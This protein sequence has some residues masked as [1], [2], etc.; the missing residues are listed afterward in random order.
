MYMFYY[1]KIYWQYMKANFSILLAY[2]WGVVHYL[3]STVG[4]TV[5]SILSVVLIAYKTDQVYGWSPEDMFLLACSYNI[6]N[7]L[8]IAIFNK[9]FRYF[10]LLMNEGG[11]DQ[12]L[13][14]PI[15]AQFLLSFQYINYF[16]MVRFLI[17]LFSTVYLVLFY[18]KIPVGFVD[19]LYFSVLMIFSLVVMYALWYTACTLTVWF[20]RLS[21]IID[22]LHSFSG[23]SRNPPEIFLHSRYKILL[24]V[25]PFAF[26]LAVPAKVLL[27][28]VTLNDVFLLIAL[29]FVF[30]VLTRMF[31][32]F[33]L[34]YYS[35]ASS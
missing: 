6:I 4:W 18:L 26:A 30:L 19:V 7:G 11:L 2:R 15:D 3:I 14:K 25:F 34:R 8:F 31:W 27:H 13:L 9:N 32:L 16:S 33:S 17:G 5:F 22:L 1:L 35:S 29:A 10:V 12:I 21:N 28:T 24:I 23:G 20:P